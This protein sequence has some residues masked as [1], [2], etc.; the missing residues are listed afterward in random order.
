MERGAVLAFL[1][2]AT[3]GL[4]QEEHKQRI[5]FCSWKCLKFVQMWPGSFC[6]ALGPRFD[7]VIP[8]DADH[9]TIHG[10]WPSNIMNCCSCWPLFP[11]DLADLSKQLA[12][13]WPTF[14][15]ASSFK[16]WRE[17]WQKH[18]TCAGCLE[19]FS[20][21]SKYFGAALA[22]RTP[23]NVD[24]AF[25]RAGIIPSCNHSYQ[26]HTL[27][28]AL[29]PIMGQEQELQCVTDGQARQV[30]VQLK[31]SLFSN[32]SAGCLEEGAQEFSPYRPCHSQSRIFYFP[33]NPKNP[34]QP[35]P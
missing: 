29:V 10:L 31:V 11:S 21:P 28:E 16:F 2:L 30:L 19:A 27:Q 18:G 3:V 22:L 33:L 32:F 14:L 24:R 8:A 34:R 6:V 35:C 1:W 15:N 25:Q 26:L 23:Y 7:C 20:S 5:G 13:H 4:L 9:W 12:E 17:E